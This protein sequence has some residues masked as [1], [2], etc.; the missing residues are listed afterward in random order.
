LPF[1]KKFQKFRTWVF[2]RAD[3]GPF[4]FLKGD[5]SPNRGKFDL[6]PNHGSPFIQL[7]TIRRV[8]PGPTTGRKDQGGP[9]GQGSDPLPF[10][11]SE[12]LFPFDLEDAGNGHAGFLFD[13]TV[14][15]PKLD[16]Q[17]P[18]QLPADSGLPGPHKAY[19]HDV[20]GA[21][22]FFQINNFSDVLGIDR[23]VFRSQT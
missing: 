7:A 1:P 16:P 3:Q 5:P 9:S 23:S 17:R 4:G 18:G 11:F 22:G 21:K 20:L 13:P 2:G 14:Q 6:Q 19:Q 12:I 8:H 10:F 15:V